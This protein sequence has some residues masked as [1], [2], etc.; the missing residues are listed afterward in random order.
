[1]VRRADIDSDNAVASSKI[2]NFEVAVE[3]TASRTTIAASRSLEG[4]ITASSYRKETTD[5]ST[6][7]A[8]TK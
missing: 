7:T 8:I 5:R 4:V 2:H 3:D 6:V 1:M